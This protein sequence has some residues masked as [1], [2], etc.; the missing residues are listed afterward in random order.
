MRAP[1]PHAPGISSRALALLGW[2]AL[3]AS[4]SVFLTLA[5]D[6]T[7]QAPLVLLDARVA[8][9]LHTHGSLELTAFLYAVTQLNSTV[10]LVAM[11]LMLLGIQARMREWY[12]MLSVAL[13]VGGGMLLNLL[14][15]HLYQ[16]ARPVFDNPWV[17]LTT[18]SFPSG[19]TAGATAFY[20][21][22]AAFLVTRTR[23]RW[24]RA[25]IVCGAAL[26]VALVA[27]S[28]MY[29]GAHYLSDVVAA[30][31]STAAWLT[32]ALSLVRSRVHRKLALQ[33][34]AAN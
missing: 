9:W 31:A 6:V 32:L 14:L 16:R 1:E 11:T 19:H 20:G 28:R 15:K 27:F 4:I 22:L 24:S 34:A 25:A 3:L 18:Y 21:V 2:G 7:T 10:G 12:W 30:A 5:W 17:M 33:A 29:L 26:A 13:V 8:N 23:D